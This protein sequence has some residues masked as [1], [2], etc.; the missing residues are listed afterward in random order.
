M[1]SHLASRGQSGSNQEESIRHEPWMFG[2]WCWSVGC[3]QVNQVSSVGKVQSDYASVFQ[4]HALTTVI[5]NHY[6]HNRRVR[7]MT[8][9]E[10]AR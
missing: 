3:N 4:V 7:I 9:L 1:A 5:Y 10:P 8:G 2:W 6:G